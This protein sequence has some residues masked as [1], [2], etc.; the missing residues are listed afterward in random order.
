MART[1]E[2]VDAELK[3][4]VTRRQVV[5]HQISGLSQEVI[6]ITKDIDRLILERLSITNPPVPD[7]PEGVE[8]AVTV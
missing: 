7:T 3:R 5:T 8:Q 4:K 2:Q 6:R 1:V